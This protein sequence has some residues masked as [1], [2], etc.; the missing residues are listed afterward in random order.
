MKSQH[1]R[2]ALAVTTA[3]AALASVGL[4]AT[5]T[6]AAAAPKSLATVLT[7]DGNKF[8]RNSGDFDVATEAV[9]T[10]LKAKPGS[11][12]GA[13]TNPTTKLTAFVPTDKA[14]MVLASDLSGKHITSEKRAFKVV[15][16]LG[17]DTVETVLLY[18]VV[19]GP[20]I[21]AKA[22]LN[23]NGAKLATAAG[24]SIK[25]KVTKRPAIILRDKDTNSRNARVIL[26]LTNIN[27]GNPQLAH[28]I[29]RVLRP[30][31]LPPTVK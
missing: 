19:V 22:A 6:P 21:N 4:A 1:T 17:V 18:H 25:V 24:P 29:D 5:V 3:G 26:K 31:D 13:L 14:F 20:K 30:V 9:L 10:V 2:R 11:A 23:A 15:A 12:V 7:S 16:G 8:D 27:K 28:G